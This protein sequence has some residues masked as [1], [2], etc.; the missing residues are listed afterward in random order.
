MIG[1]I[2]MDTLHP[3]ILNAVRQ[4]LAEDIG[5]GDITSNSIISV[6][7]LM[8]GR[9]LSKQEGVIAGLA[10]ARAVYQQLEPRVQ[11]LPETSDG[12]RVIIGQ[13]LVMVSGAAR[14]LLT[15]ERTALNFLGRMSG[16][17]TLTRRFVDAVAGTKAVILD[18]RK[19][20]PGLR[21]LEKLA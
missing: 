18:T 6:D 14:H 9:I 20:A 13:T 4:A 8:R 3:A 1:P 12:S 19:T 21:Q 15:A 17:A 10:V 7:A 11:F 2:I 5:S 16:I